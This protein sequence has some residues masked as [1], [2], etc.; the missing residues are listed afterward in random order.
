MKKF[1]L[2][3]FLIKIDAYS[4]NIDITEALNSVNY[5]NIQK[6]E[7]MLL[8][9][10][11][12]NPSDPSVL[13]LDAI[14]TKN[15]EEAIKKYLYLYEKFPDS[16]YSDAALF[17]IFSYYFSIGLYKTANKYLDELRN[18]FPESAFLKNANR[19]LPDTIPEE[20]HNKKFTIQAG[21]FL[22]FDNAKRLS[23]LLKKDGYYTE[24]TT[25]EV[26]GSILNVVNCGQFIS[27][28][29]ANKKL[30]ELEEK[31]KIKGRIVVLDN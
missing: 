1:L 25:K 13:Y 10:K 29:E 19:N 14:L 30:I 16:K 11:S 2:I 4:Q 5:G 28:E 22:V 6:A 7:S 15:G 3:I 24:I 18:K 31:Y 8:K 23:E 26:G 27:E 9:F 17:N 12:E 21:A 20:N